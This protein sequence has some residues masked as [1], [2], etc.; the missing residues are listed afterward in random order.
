MSVSE[1][2]GRRAT[3]AEFGVAVV[4]EVLTP[5]Y[6]EARLNAALK[7]LL[8]T[9][10]WLSGF[11]AGMRSARATGTRVV[12]DD[13]QERRFAVTVRAEL[14]A[15]VGPRALALGIDTGIELDL[16][17]RVHA[18]RPAIIGVE[19]DPVVAE[20]VRIST[21]ARSD[22]LPRALL[23]D[24]GA[25]LAGTAQR[26]AP[27]VVAAVNRAL[28][29]TSAHRQVDVL[30]RIHRYQRSDEGAG[31][32]VHTG[33]LGPGER[34]DRPLDLD[35][36]EQA[37]LRLWAGL[38]GGAVSGGAVSGEPGEVRLE[39]TGPDDA[40]VAATNLPVRRRVPDLD[41]A[42]APVTVPAA[43]AAGYRVRLTNR[44]GR[45]VAYRVAEAR[46]VL[47]GDRIGFAEFGAVLIERGITRE[48][49]ADAVARQ[50]ARNEQSMFAAPAMVRGTATPRLAEVR[51]GPS[52]ADELCFGLALDIGL[53]LVVGP[54]GNATTLATTLRAEV[55]LRIT[56]TVAP[57]GLRLEFAPVPA[58]ATRV[59]APLHRVG[60]R[61]LPIP[62]R[63]LA[64]LL[65]ERVAAELN[66][67][68]AQAGR[69]IVAAE[70]AS[71]PPPG[72]TEPVVLL[73]SRTGFSGTTSA[74]APVPH[75]VRLAEGQRIEVTARISPEPDPTEPDPTEPDPAGDPAVE[76]AP[77]VELAVC[78]EHGGVWATDRAP[79]PTV[80]P[81]RLHVMFTA[82]ETGQWRLRVTADGSAELAYRIGVRP[83]RADQDEAD[84]GDDEPD[85]GD[86]PDGATTAP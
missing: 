76:P 19:I 8:R 36:R 40:L 55:P 54:G 15:E 20:D 18:F 85:D 46:T 30:D 72:F 49:V 70:V 60:G 2:A 78:D 53:E 14:A 67:R 27:L 26:S 77:A 43:E 68:L 41:T 80:L 28:A 44:T 58:A 74:G 81:V 66:R 59:V 63:K 33:T 75:P 35:E 17:V 65:P 1:G 37:R 47:P 39:V 38:T 13:G 50:L 31:D 45:P 48:A 6:V 23:D 82:P 9:P 57:A 3:F 7:S 5:G 71:G 32:P 51:E 22:W 69:R 24:G 11:P 12:A 42:P 73:R 10:A 62:R 4:D 21:S 34:L 79:V 61:H 64:E 52:T 84:D 25:R 86:E 16:T 29:S 56:T 83:V